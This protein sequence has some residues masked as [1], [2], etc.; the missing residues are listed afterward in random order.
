VHPRAAVI[1]SIRSENLNSRATQLGCSAF[2]VINH[3][4][5]NRPSCEVA[6]VGR[7]RPEYLHKSTL[8]DV[9]DPKVFSGLLHLQT[10]HFSKEFDRR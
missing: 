5:D 8:W 4:T 3:K 7:S 2:D 1:G 9:T 10:Q 6:I